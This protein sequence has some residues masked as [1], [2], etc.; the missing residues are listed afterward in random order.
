MK[1]KSLARTGNQFPSA[2]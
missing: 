1:V 2:Y